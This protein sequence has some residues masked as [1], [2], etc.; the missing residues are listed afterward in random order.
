ML[1]L[2]LPTAIPT[3]FGQTVL[4]VDRSRGSYTATIG[5]VADCHASTACTFAT[6]DGEAGHVN[7]RGRRAVGLANG[8]T[9]WFE[10]HACGANCAGSATLV[11]Q[12]AGSRYTIAVKAGTLAQTVQIANGLRAKQ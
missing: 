7:R 10:E 9:A 8:T 12:R 11:F 1:P 3:A 6:V 5:A 2:L 4:T